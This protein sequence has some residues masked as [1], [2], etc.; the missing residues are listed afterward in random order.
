MLRVEKRHLGSLA[1]SLILCTG[2]AGQ[3]S[4]APVDDARVD[5][6]EG[7]VFRSLPSN[8]SL[9]EVT[10]GTSELVLD[11]KGSTEGTSSSREGPWSGRANLPLTV[12]S[13]LPEWSTVIQASPLKG[14]RGTIPP[15]RLWVRTEGTE[16]AYEPM[17]HPVPV[18]HGDASMGVKTVSA[19]IEA[20]PDWT[21]PPGRY[22]GEIMVS[23]GL[24][25]AIENAPRKN[26][27]H[28]PAFQDQR[29][30]VS[31][32]IP[33]VIMV[34]V[35]AV[36]LDFD[37]LSGP[38]QYTA[39]EEVCFHVTSNAEYWRVECEAAPLVYEDHEI[40]AER[41]RWSRLDEIGREISGYSIEER[42]TL[43]EGIGSVQ[44]LEIRIKFSLDVLPIDRAGSYKGK[45]SL[46]GLTGQ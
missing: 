21:D 11:P 43:A 4:Q 35:G 27:I 28:F 19:E 22:E 16:G 3:S 45:I 18:A 7:A 38:G 1:L 8:E 30:Y 10:P 29:I 15:E 23:G 20:R 17:D 9:I 36:E 12:Q 32:Q 42:T 24:P 33:E 14:E 34:S 5:R 13:M 2:L 25:S 40:P 41:I 31:I 46:V 44:D 26:R 37:A 39:E 6:E